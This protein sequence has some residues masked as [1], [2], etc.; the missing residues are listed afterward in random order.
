MS[1]LS[2]RF[3]YPLFLVRIAT[4]SKHTA[5]KSS[6]THVPGYYLPSLRTWVSSCLTWGDLR[7]LGSDFIETRAGLVGDMADG[8]RNGSE[9]QDYPFLNGEEFAEICHHLDRKYRRATLG[10]VRKQWRL[11]VCTALSTS[12]TPGS[13]YTTYIQIVRPL[14]GELDDD[15][16]SSR[17]DEFSLDVRPASPEVG[18][19]TEDDKD[20]IDAEEA[21]GVRS[22]FSELHVKFPTLGY[23]CLTH[24]SSPQSALRSQ[25]AKPTFGHVTYEIHLHPT[26]RCPCLWFN[27]RGLPEDEPA[28][29]ID[30]VFRRLVPDQYKDGLRAAGTVGGI[31]ADVSQYMMLLIWS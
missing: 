7:I 26:Y 4:K 17:L 3:L 20:M 12:F 23:I 10:P 13:E 5:V 15:G 16:L 27:L 1:F 2:T 29:N 25:P 28:F 30:T 31:S 22:I 18:M 24:E 11:N 9:F 21:D 14:E 8:L 19:V 6:S